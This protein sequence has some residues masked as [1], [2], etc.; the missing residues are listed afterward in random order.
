MEQQ[1]RFT[2]QWLP[3]ELL[4]RVKGMEHNWI[5][6]DDDRLPFP[7]AMSVGRSPDGRLIC[8]ALYIGNLDLGADYDPPPDA[9]EWY[10]SERVEVTAR[11]L[12]GLPLATLLGSI[13]ALRDDPRGRAFFREIFR[14]ADNLDAP[15]RRRPGPKG[16][17]RSHFEDVAKRY[18]A[19]L[20]YAPHAPIKTLAPQLHASEA[21]VRRWVQRARDMG[22]LGP[23]TPGRAGEGPARVDQRSDTQATGHRVTG[24]DIRPPIADP[25]EGS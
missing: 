25:E 6:F 16:H 13:E 7:V 17:P 5:G 10:G 22:L 20:A 21:T 19:V 12:R 14:L 23:S 2:P 24:D 8:T 1:P 4:M 9:P 3:S 11:G 15:P 18:R